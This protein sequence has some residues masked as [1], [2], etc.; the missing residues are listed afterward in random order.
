VAEIWVAIGTGILALATFVLAGITA[1][2]VSKTA[3][4]V[5]ATEKSAAAAKA[6]VDE[7]QRDRELE[8]RPYL[9]WSVKKGVM[10]GADATFA[11]VGNFGRGPAIH[12]LCCVGWTEAYGGGRV[13]KLRTTGLFDLSPNEPE[14]RNMVLELRSGVQLDSDMAGSD[15]GEDPVRVAFSQDQ[16]GNYFRFVPYHVEADVYNPSKDKA[17]PRWMVFY[18]GQVDQL[19]KH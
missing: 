13:P 9:S 12:C 11:N 5:T 8:Y 3:G 2:N 1:W 15:V 7:I 18:R 6:T 17:E 4:L 19:A 16:L 10:A 14:N